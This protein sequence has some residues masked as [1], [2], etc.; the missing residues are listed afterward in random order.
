MATTAKLDDIDQEL[1]RLL[2]ENG[3]AGNRQLGQVL[4]VSEATVRNRI[5]RLIDSRVLHVTAIVDFEASGSDFLVMLLVQ[6]EG[7]SV[8]DVGREL[9]AIP[10]VIAVS[11]VSGRCDLLVT[12][13][14]R[15]K[16]DMCHVIADRVGGIEGV[17]N[18]Q[19]S[20]ALDVVLSRAEWA[21][22]L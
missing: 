7:R 12:F 20:V 3:R 5:R 22:V 13:L 11:I 17:R 10:R 18:V 15:D 16:T 14:A 6:V 8:R 9:A 21:G 19:S 4:G 2:R 1:I